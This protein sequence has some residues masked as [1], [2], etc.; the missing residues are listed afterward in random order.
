MCLVVPAGPPT[1]GPGWIGTIPVGA[2]LRCP[3]PGARWR[4]RK[5]KEPAAQS[6]T[7]ILYTEYKVDMKVSAQ[8]R[9]CGPGP[10]R[11]RQPG[12]GDLPGRAKH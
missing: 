8:G 12:S 3:G 6:V 2:T 1:L 9:G 7:D 10:R 11:W 4:G 5:V